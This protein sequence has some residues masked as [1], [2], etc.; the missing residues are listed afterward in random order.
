MMA[1]LEADEYNDD[2]D[3]KATNITLLII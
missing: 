1:Y 3:D 2:D